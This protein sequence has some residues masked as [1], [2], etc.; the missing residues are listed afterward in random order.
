MARIRS[1]G[2]AVL[3]TAFVI[4]LLLA[5]PS[6]QAQ[7][8][9]QT[10]FDALVRGAELPTGTVPRLAL[11]D[12]AGIAARTAADGVIHLGRDFAGKLT[13]KQ[14]C[15][16]L[17]HE[18]AHLSLSHKPSTDAPMGLAQE[19]ETDRYAM[20]ILARAGYAIVDYRP[21]LEKLGA[22]ADWK[23]AT[24]SDW[25]ARSEALSREEANLRH[26]KHEFHYARALLAIGQYRT[27]ISI[28]ERLEKAFPQ[29]VSILNNLAS[30]YLGLYMA[31]QDPLEKQAQAMLVGTL[32]ARHIAPLLLWGVS[33]GVHFEPEQ[34]LGFAGS[35]PSEL[36]EALRRLDQALEQDPRRVEV[37]T[38]RLTTLTWLMRH[39]ERF[40]SKAAEAKESLTAQLGNRAI[41]DVSRAHACNNLALYFYEV[42]GDFRSFTIWMDQARALESSFAAYNRGLIGLL[43]PRVGIGKEKAQADL[44]SALASFGS[45]RSVQ[46]IIAAVTGKETTPRA[47]E[48]TIIDT[49]AAKFASL[50][51]SRVEDDRM[52]LEGAVSTD[53]YTIGRLSS[54]AMMLT[55]T[56]EGQTMGWIYL[57][58][59]VVETLLAQT[60]AESADPCAG[61]NAYLPNCA[62]NPMD[63]VPNDPAFLPMDTSPAAKPGVR[64]DIGVIVEI[65]GIEVEKL[66][67][68][69]R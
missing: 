62:P 10:V 28:L 56:Q 42:M 32:D 53:T 24:T 9:V 7:E 3:S 64:F 20:L 6:A 15:A 67:P 49:V 61:K 1:R 38:N 54:G 2:I 25:K 66:Y 41:S 29:S 13:K 19:I 8:E 44:E 58:P 45:T 52:L 12:D 60:P 55:E 30:A 21:A 40:K 69:R 14:L 31:G 47:P 50:I 23:H 37:L 57:E 4:L 65:K 59:S 39:D 46:G 18:L 51:A 11:V 68:I 48:R 17:A 36:T 5:N 35:L 34:T 22:N 33:V 43:D 63:L 16:I 26:L 27:A